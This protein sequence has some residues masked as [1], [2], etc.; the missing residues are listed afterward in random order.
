MRLLRLIAAALL[1][2]AMLIGCSSQDCAYY[3]GADASARCVIIGPAPTGG[4]H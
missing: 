3:G 4:G 1:T 2:A